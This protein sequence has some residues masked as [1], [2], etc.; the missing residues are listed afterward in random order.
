[1]STDRT[2][3][4]LR[5]G[6]DGLLPG[7]VQ[8]ATTGE[9]LMLGYLTPE[10]WQKTLE[11]GLV[12]FWSRERQELWEKGATSGNYLRLQAARLDCDGD[13]LL[14]AV[15][16]DGPTCHTG[17]R[18]CFHWAVDLD[19]SHPE[20]LKQSEPAV[21]STG[22]AID[23]LFAVVLD[24]Q[25]TMPDGSYTRYLF[26]EGIDKID[27]KMGEE[28]AEV[29]VASKNGVPEL[30]A[31]EM[32]DLYFHSLVLLAACGLSMDDVWQQLRQRRR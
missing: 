5:W 13:T 28:V 23:E 26:E 7:V 17:E 10:S 25:R 14:L 1:M 16:P 15:L 9:V 31:A 3:P 20:L 8:H 12:W 29:I 19:E 11:T 2:P 4:E 22:S 27:K 32:A 18:S 21:A 24:R 6:A 30:L